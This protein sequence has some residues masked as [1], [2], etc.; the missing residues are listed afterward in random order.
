MATG[1]AQWGN[2]LY[3]GRRSYDIVGRRRTW[4][5]ITAALV[6]ISG[7]LLITPGL[8]PGIEF[9]GGSEFVVSGVETS[10]QQLATDTVLA[11]APQEVPRVTTVGGSSLRIQTAELTSDEVTEVT[12]GLIAAFD[13]SEDQVTST[14][15]GPT[16]GRDVSQKA[17]TGLVVFLLFVSLVMTVY[18]RNW[19]MAAA[20]MLALFHDLILTVGIYAAVGWEVTPATVIGFLTILGYSIYDTVVVFDKVRE[21]TVDTLDQTRFTYA[22]KANLAVNQTLV[23][24]INTSVVALLPVASILVIGAFILGA[25]TLR[26]IAL[27][28]FVGM[29]VG[30]FSSIFLATPLEVTLRE[31]EARVKAHTTKVL[32]ARTGTVVDGEPVAAAPRAVAALRPGSHQGTAAQPKRKG[33]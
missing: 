8:N 27:A 16:W 11:V 5:V 28:L 2:D 29:F 10:D 25:G 20:A 13:V 21:N 30:T 12:N 3:S 19:R 17:V 15:I 1:F 31:R 23:R 32:A 22:E 24:S 9:R 7:V 18:F 14:F 26:D 33:R 4:Y 6:A